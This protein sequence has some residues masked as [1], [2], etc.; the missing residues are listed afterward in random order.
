MTE[1]LLERYHCNCG[2]GFI[3]LKKYRVGRVGSS[4]IIEGYA[5]ISPCPIC[6]GTVD[7]HGRDLKKLVKR[8]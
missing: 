4:D 3:T 8:S 2:K 1:F 7:I 6:E 5:S